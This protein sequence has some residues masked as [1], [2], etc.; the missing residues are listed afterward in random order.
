MTTGKA[1]AGGKY[2]DAEGELD[3]DA[4][5]FNVEGCDTP[6]LDIVIHRTDSTKSIGEKEV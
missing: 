5:V 4:V 3:D 1:E 6:T 2:K